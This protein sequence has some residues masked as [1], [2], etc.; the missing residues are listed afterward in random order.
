[1]P[2]TSLKYLNGI[3]HVRERL[4][5]PAA[6]F[7]QQQTLNKLQLPHATTNCMKK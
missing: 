4:I 3:V 6:V 1:M 7:A 5:D 2:P